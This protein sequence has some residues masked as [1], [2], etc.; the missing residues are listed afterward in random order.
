LARIAGLALNS[1]RQRA[2]KASPMRVA[3]YPLYERSPLDRCSSH[4]LLQSLSPVSTPTSS[5]TP[6]E[7]IRR[8]P[9]S[10]ERSSPVAESPTSPVVISAVRDGGDSSC[11]CAALFS[12]GSSYD[13]ATTAVRSPQQ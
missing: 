12:I 6:R 5:T 4:R 10:P 1:Q 8:C 11:W 9:L 3:A 13:V 7:P 2:A